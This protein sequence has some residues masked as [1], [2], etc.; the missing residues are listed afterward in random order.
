LIEIDVSAL[1]SDEVPITNYGVSSTG[2]ALISSNDGSLIILE[3]FQ[4]GTDEITISVSDGFDS[5]AS[6][7]TTVEVFNVSPLVNSDAPRS[8]QLNIDEGSTSI[9]LSDFITDQDSPNLEYDFNIDNLSLVSATRNQDV[10]TLSPQ[11]EGRTELTISLN[12]GYEMVS[13]VIEVIVSSA[14][15]VSTSQFV[16][17]VYPNPV[18]DNLIW[19][20]FE[21]VE[22][23]ENIILN[24][25]LG[26]ETNITWSSEDGR[27]K[28]SLQDQ[29]K[30]IFLLNVLRENGQKYTKKLIVE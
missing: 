26:R 18:K 29:A 19:V 16:T 17:N 20:E 24:D 15:N 1:F 22:K 27:I 9:T 13:S 30:G 2:S 4:L 12:D 7:T 28:I 11:R 21:G 3:P 14:L 6:L 23:V 10:L 25:L 5:L 8:I